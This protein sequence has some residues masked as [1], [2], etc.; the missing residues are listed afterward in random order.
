MTH[1]PKDNHTHHN[2]SPSHHR[3]HRRRRYNHRN[4]HINYGRRRHFGHSSPKSINNCI[5]H[6]GI[7]I[8]IRNRKTKRSKGGD[9]TLKGPRSRYQSQLIHGKN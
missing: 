3:H 6:V 5:V 9:R 4:H 1:L 7:E 8:E 2:H